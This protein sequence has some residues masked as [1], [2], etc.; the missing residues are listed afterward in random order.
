M[1]DEKYPIKTAIV[2]TKPITKT[3]AGKVEPFQST[4]LCPVRCFCGAE[5]QSKYTV[6][7]QRIRE[8][9]SIKQALDECGVAMSSPFCAP[10]DTSFV[11]P[12]NVCCRATIMANSDLSTEHNMYQ[13][14]AHWGERQQP[15]IQLEPTTK[16]IKHT[17]MVVSSTTK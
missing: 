13:W 14:F 3:V 1:M 4:K 2:A 17:V 15:A 5:L 9:K 10:N 6:Y 11:S 7:W 16:P 12:P 8:G